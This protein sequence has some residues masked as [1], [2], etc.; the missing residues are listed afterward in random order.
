MSEQHQ[1]IQ[2]IVKFF[3]WIAAI[4][5]GVSAL[6]SVTG[7]LLLQSHAHLLGVSRVFHHTVEDYLY[8]G[9]NFFITTLFW[10]LPVAIIGN[11]YIWIAAGLIVI[12]LLGKR[13]QW[14]GDITQRLHTQKALQQAWV[15]WVAIL[16]AAILFLLFIN[17]IIPPSS[18]QD[19]LF[20]ARHHSEVLKRATPEETEILKNQYLLSLL[21]V[22]LSAL[23]LW[24]I[25]RIHRDP[26]N[27]SPA[28]LLYVYDRLTGKTSEHQVP[29]NTSK[30]QAEL[31]SALGRLFLYLLFLV[32]LA[33]LPIQYG[34]TVYPNTFHRVS[35]LI[36]DENLQ[37]KI[38]QSQNIY[39]LNERG[40]EL[41]LYFGDTQEVS[42]VKKANVVNIAIKAREN[43]FQ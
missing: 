1:I 25:T 31:F 26:E 4:T 41:I 6:L 42:L 7:F 13:F 8:Q 38:P 29:E 10:A 20:A 9:G 27:K 12:Y 15:G 5:A 24:I 3:G 40:D 28:A 34:K 14:V 11:I 18:A 43:I 37:G 36:L 16:A 23:I 32:Q 33:L 35:N 21:Y 39:L 17:H 30:P 2:N 19:L 22:N